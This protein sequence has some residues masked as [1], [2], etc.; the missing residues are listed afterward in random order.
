MSP[1][2]A[3]VS[4]HVGNALEVVETHEVGQDTDQGKEEEPDTVEQEAGDLESE[5]ELHREEARDVLRRRPARM[6][7]A[8]ERRRHEVMHMPFRDWC[9]VCVA[10]AANDRG[11]HRGDGLKEL[12]VPEVHFDYCFPRSQ[13]GGE[14]IVVLVARDREMRMTF[15][16]VVPIK[17]GELDWISEQVAR[18]LLKLGHHGN[19]ILRSDQEP[20]ITDVLNRVAK[21]R[22]TSRTHLE[23]SPVGDSRANGVA[24]RAI[25]T[26]EKLLRV[27]MLALADRLG[28]TVPVQHPLVEWLIEHVAGLYNRVAVGTDGRTAVQR[29]KGKACS[30]F[31]VPFGADVMFRVCGKVDGG[32][33]AERWHSGH[34]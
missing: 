14:Y 20:A 3:L 33:L 27:H 18:D 5:D 10:G 29:L 28:G 9:K 21:L 17:G 16:H 32:N 31:M 6:P 13:A 7:S 22:G 19:L 23:Q 12:A 1:D 15:A 24:E 25:Q 26:I 8:E 30:G 4:P 11:H 2:E 34:G